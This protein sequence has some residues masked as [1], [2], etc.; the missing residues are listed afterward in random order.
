[1]S[2]MA[3][4]GFAA[5][6]FLGFWKFITGPSQIQADV[7]YP[8]SYRTHVVGQAGSG[9]RLPMLIAL[10]GAGADEED[11]NGVFEDWQVPVRIVSFRAPARAG[12][13]Y[14]WSYGEGMSRV[15][16]EAVEKQMFREVAQSLAVGAAEVAARYPTVGKPMVFGFSRGGSM[17]WYLGAHHPEEFDAIFVVAG[18]LEAI[19]FKGLNPAIRPPFF[20]YHGR[21][22]PVVGIQGGHR[23]AASIERLAGQVVFEEFDGGHTVPPS[24]GSDVEQQIKILRGG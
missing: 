7:S 13:G 20:A 18:E 3:K 2:P 11:L 1:M 17:A 16:A 6:F 4:M 10:H 14:T 9:D 15:E 5:V 23:T 21:R 22:D 12:R 8:L 24:V 19:F